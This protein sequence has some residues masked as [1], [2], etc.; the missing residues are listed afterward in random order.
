MI[1]ATLYA[2][3]AIAV[4]LD[5]VLQAMIWLLIELCNSTFAMSIETTLAW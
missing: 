1:M 5:L 3:L 2:A 4:P